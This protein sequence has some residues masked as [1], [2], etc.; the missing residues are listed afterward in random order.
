MRQTMEINLIK[1]KPAKAILRFAIPLILANLFFQLY[2]TVDTIIVGRYNGDAALAAVGA[3]FA[4]TMVMI[5]FATGT[6]TGCA[7]LISRYFGGERKSEVKTSVSTVLIFSFLFSVFIAVMGIVF[8]R[9][10]LILLAT[11]D[12]IIGDAAAY[13]AIYSMGMP[14]AFLYNVQSSIFSAFGNSKM[15]LFLLM[16]SSVMNIGLDFLLVGRFAMGVEGAAVATVAAQGFA[17]VVSFVLLIRYVYGSENFKEVRY[18]YF[19]F[20]ILKEMM[21]YMAVSVFQSSIT[22]IGLLL[23]QSVV[24]PFGSDILAGYIAGNKIDSFAIVP[25]MAC[26]NALATYTSQNIGAGKSERVRQGYRACLML[27]GGI[28]IL[29]LSVILLFRFSLI[30]FY[31][32]PETSSPEALQT[33]VTYITQMS[34]FYILMGVTSSQSGMIRGEGRLTILFWNCIIS[35]VVR[36]GFAFTMV[37]VIGVSAVWLSLPAGWIVSILYCKVRMKRAG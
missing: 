36:V 11:P 13:L 31:L 15:S 12:N 35:L 17:F 21:S 5:A 25:F 29:I 37:H 7:V 1:E 27:C 22:S 28:G 18:Q 14:F 6:G 8:S 16:L 19:S 30:G 4:V 23:V 3:S 34:V 10:L 24:N 32:R 20:S 33:A 2:E 26:G 9:P